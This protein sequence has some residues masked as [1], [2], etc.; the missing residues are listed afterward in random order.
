M[1]FGPGAE[2]ISYEFG[3]WQK[4]KERMALDWQGL[5]AYVHALLQF[6]KFLL[7][8]TQKPLHDSVAIS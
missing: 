3:L 5:D 6:M 1:E 2:E 7:D 4:H 8:G